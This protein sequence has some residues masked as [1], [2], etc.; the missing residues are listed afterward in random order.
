M[1]EF[2]AACLIAGAIAF[3]AAVILDRFLQEPVSVAFAEPGVRV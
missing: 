1:R 3:G 2:I